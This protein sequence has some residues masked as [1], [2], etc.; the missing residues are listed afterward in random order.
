MLKNIIGEGYK[1]L[2]FPQGEAIKKHKK[3]SDIVLKGGGVRGAAKLF[4][5]IEFGHVFGG[6]NNK[7]AFIQ[8]CRK[9]VLIHCWI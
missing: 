2:N 5:K 3:I 7:H 4:I 6:G 1:W 9:L 8:G